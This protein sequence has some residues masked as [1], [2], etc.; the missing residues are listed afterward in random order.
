MSSKCFLFRWTFRRTGKVW[1]NSK[2][3]GEARGFHGARTKCPARMLKIMKN[4]LRTL[5]T[6]PSY[7]EY[8]FYGWVPLPLLPPPGLGAALLNQL[9]K[10]SPSQGGTT[11]SYTNLAI[12]EVSFDAA[13]VYLQSSFTVLTSKF[14]LLCFQ[15]AQSS[16]CEESCYCWIFGDCICITFY[17]IHILSG[18]KKAI[19]LIFKIHC[20]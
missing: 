7:Q 14:P 15:V 1:Q 9:I 6:V 13:A 8:T 4:I 2:M 10:P 5:V 17:G 11:D 16:I 3:S 20:I 19:P 12:E 18:G